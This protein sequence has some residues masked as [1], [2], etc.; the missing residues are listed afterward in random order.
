MRGGVRVR[1]PVGH[2][3]EHW[4]PCL[5]SPQFLYKE[6]VLPTDLLILAWEFHCNPKITTKSH[7]ISCHALKR[8]VSKTWK[9]QTYCSNLTVFPLSPIHY[10]LF[11][12]HP[13]FSSCWFS[14]SW[15]RF[16]ITFKIPNLGYINR[17]ELSFCFSS[18]TRYLD[19]LSIQHFALLK[20]RK[21]KA[22]LKYE[23]S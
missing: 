12:F 21:K 1:R 15:L 20:K 16:M 5:V 10:P 18:R 14:K 17:L 9:M 4:S 13:G 22:Y 3:S 23:A 6:G 2:F 19:Y 7:S 11:L 8:T